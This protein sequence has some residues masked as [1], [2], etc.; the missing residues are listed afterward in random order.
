MMDWITWGTTLVSSAYVYTKY[1]DANNNILMTI[2]NTATS[3]KVAVWLSNGATATGTTTAIQFRALCKQHVAVV[4]NGSGATD[5]DRL[6]V[7]IDG[8]LVALTFTGAAIPATTANLAAANLKTG[9]AAG[10]NEPCTH[11][12]MQILVPALTAA[13]VRAE[14]LK[15]GGQHLTLRETLEDV[16]VTLAASV[17]APGQIGSWQLIAGSWKCSEDVTGKRSLEN[18]LAGDSARPQPFAFGTWI[19]RIRS[20]LMAAGPDAY[21]IFIASVATNNYADPGQNGYMLYVNNGTAYLFKITAGAATNLAN[22]GVLVADTEYEFCIARRPSDGRFTVWIR[23]GTYLVWTQI[24]QV[25]D[26]AFTTSSWINLRATGNVGTTFPIFDPK[27]SNVALLHYQGVLD[28]TAGELS[29][30]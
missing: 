29:K 15:T 8:E 11:H 17:A 2:S 19:F 12:S 25:V 27:D 18:V 14:Y 9:I 24:I 4:F 13:Q 30:W 3:S 28:P 6:K 21:C 20:K 5:A 7:Y 22:A 16:P 26:V 10:F 1:V 23:G